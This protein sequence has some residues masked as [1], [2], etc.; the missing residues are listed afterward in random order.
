MLRTEIERRVPQLT[1]RAAST[2]VLRFEFR[3]PDG[4]IWRD[5]RV[6]MPLQGQLFL[7]LEPG[8]GFTLSVEAAVVA[9][10]RKA[11]RR[12]RCFSANLVPAALWSGPCSARLGSPN[13][14]Q[15]ML[16]KR[17][18]ISRRHATARAS[19]RRSAHRLPGRSLT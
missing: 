4:T 12:P 5:V 10:N 7:F 16:G 19:T 14:P 3:V 8:A 18:R 6:A 17:L 1:D 13:R 9:L 11:Q 2:Q 15:D